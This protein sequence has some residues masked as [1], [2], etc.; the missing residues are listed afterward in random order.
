M[1][2]ISG[3]LLCAMTSRSPTYRFHEL[4]HK[5]S[6]V[7]N[8]LKI[9]LSGKACA[10][11]Y[12]ASFTCSPI[13]YSTEKH[14]LFKS[15]PVGNV[16]SPLIDRK[17]TDGINDLFSLLRPNTCERGNFDAVGLAN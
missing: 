13:D 2:F 17:N 1:L 4:Y 6:D 14:M 11:A 9:V 10:C 16:Q 8:Y 15:N 12:T 7:T 3:D 5:P